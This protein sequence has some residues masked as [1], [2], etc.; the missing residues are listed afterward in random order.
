MN[1]TIL[2][3]PCIIMYLSLSSSLPPFHHNNLYTLPSS[4]FSLSLPFS[5]SPLSPL[6][7]SLFLFPSPCRYD[8]VEF[9]EPI[10]TVGNGLLVSPN[11]GV[12]YDRMYC[13]AACPVEYQQLVKN[14]LK[15]GGILI[16]PIQESSV[17]LK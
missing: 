16:T 10:F 4:P 2:K 12:L 1:Y 15:V 7:L 11:G 9:C 17:S 3:C 6:S 5:P 13:G 14:M 8:P